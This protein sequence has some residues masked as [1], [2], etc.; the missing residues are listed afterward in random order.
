M[1]GERVLQAESRI[2]EA[3]NPCGI[4]A[5][6]RTGIEHQVEIRRTRPAFGQVAADHADAA[7]ADDAVVMTESGGLDIAKHYRRR[8]MIRPHVPSS[9]SW[10]RRNGAPPP[11]KPRGGLAALAG[12]GGKPISLR[13]RSVHAS[14]VRER[15]RAD[16]RR[17]CRRGIRHV[18]H[19]AAQ[20]AA[21]ARPRTRAAREQAS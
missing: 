3:M 19:S 17:C 6:F 15:S 7:K 5:V 13:R 8:K 12:K 14:S 21:L 16:H 4:A 2:R 20:G 1:N 10:A 11:R 9:P 18:N